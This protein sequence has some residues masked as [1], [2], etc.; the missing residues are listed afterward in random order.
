MRD[1]KLP[2]RPSD[3]Y[4]AKLVKRIE[5]WSRNTEEANMYVFEDLDVILESCMVEAYKNK[6]F[7]GFAHIE[8]LKEY[9]KVTFPLKLT[10]ELNLI[11][12]LPK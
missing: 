1:Q 8:R 2:P 3:E 12:S 11:K 7:E 9:L 6:H 4:I 5:V 10:T